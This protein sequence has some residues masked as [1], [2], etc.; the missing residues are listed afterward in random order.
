MFV[1]ESAALLVSTS[2]S[3]LLSLIHRRRGGF[4]YFTTSFQAQRRTFQIKTKNAK[5]EQESD[6]VSVRF[7]RE[8]RSS[9]STF[10]LTDFLLFVSSQLTPRLVRVRVQ[11][12]D[13]RTR[14]RG[15]PAALER[16]AAQT[17]RAHTQRPTSTLRDIRESC[18][19]S[20]LRMHARRARCSTLRTSR[21]Q[22]ERVDLD[23]VPLPAR[24][25]RDSVRS[26]CG[27]AA[28]QHAA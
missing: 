27:P 22:T 10:P 4:G 23:P 20:L 21:A 14:S 2:R 9:R 6:P 25:R 26:S 18:G 11:L 12:G 19:R 1:D 15:V 24:S 3:C 16:D 5:S 8:E 7:S 17:Q 28:V 13:K